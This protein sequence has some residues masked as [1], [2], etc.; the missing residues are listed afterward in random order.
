MS[1]IY[2]IESETDVEILYK[3]GFTKDEENLQKRV[4]L[5]QEIQESAGLLKSLK[6]NSI[7]K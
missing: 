6:L 5:E 4:Q 7:E 3:I 1:Y 2:L